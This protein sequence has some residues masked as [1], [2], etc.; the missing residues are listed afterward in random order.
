[1]LE[2]EEE[3]Y[4]ALLPGLLKDEGKYAL[5]C[6][7]ALKGVYAAYEDA[8]TQG[9]KECG[10]KPFLVRKISAVEQLHY[11]SRDLGPSCPA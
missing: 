7:E 2:I 4:R 11:F 10:L 3:T 1:M 5:V 8:L 9:Y 6:G